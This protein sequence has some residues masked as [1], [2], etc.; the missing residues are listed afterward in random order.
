VREPTRHLD[1]DVNTARGSLR[2]TGEH[3]L[4]RDDDGIACEKR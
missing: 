1:P 4:D 2:H 3:D